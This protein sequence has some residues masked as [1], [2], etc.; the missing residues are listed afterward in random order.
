MIR[1]I[2]RFIEHDRVPLY[3]IHIE[4]K[5][6]WWYEGFVD[7]HLVSKSTNKKELLKE[8]NNYCEIQL[9]KLKQA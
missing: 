4:K 8:L 5:N 9:I 1:P 2:I 7:K 3:K 6:N